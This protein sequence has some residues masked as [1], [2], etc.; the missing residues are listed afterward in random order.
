MNPLKAIAPEFVKKIYRRSRSSVKAILRPK[1]AVCRIRDVVIRVG[2]V[3]ENEQDRVVTYDTKEP[4]TLDWLDQNLRDGDVFMDVGANIGLYSLYAASI[5]GNCQVY[6]FEPASQNFARLCN[7]IAL[8]SL[9]NITPCSFPLSDHESFD[10][11]YIST[12]EP[13]MSLHSF[14]QESDYSESF[15][16]RQGAIGV[17][18]DTLVKKYGMA[19]PSLIKIDVDGIEE[20]ILEGAEAVLR[21]DDCRTILIEWSFRDEADV[22]QLEDRMASSGYRLRKRSNW[23]AELSGLKSQNF[24][25]DRQ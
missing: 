25:F 4:E 23:T 16:M 1:T 7:N 21:A 19:Q 12:L 24:I 14:G 18:L 10:F 8:N 5:N 11:F 2:T 6:A 22:K 15:A 9:T 3:S 13:G 20:K 17:P